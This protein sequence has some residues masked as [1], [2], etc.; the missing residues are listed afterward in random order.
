MQHCQ[1]SQISKMSVGLAR[2]RKPKETHL[3][4]QVYA[5]SGRPKIPSSRLEMHDSFKSGMRRI[6]E[7]QDWEGRKD[8]ARVT[9][10]AASAGLA[11]EQPVQQVCIFFTHLV[12]TRRW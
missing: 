2:L 4:A 12:Q 9:R 3:V 7:S 1:C 5:D 10:S 6:L 8:F 11:S